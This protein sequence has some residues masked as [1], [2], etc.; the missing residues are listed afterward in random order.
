MNEAVSTSGSNSNWDR[1]TKRPAM[2]AGRTADDIETWE[3]LVERVR[4]VAQ[5]RGWNKTEVGR[6]AEFTSSAFSQWYS[7]SY[8][9]RL[10]RQNEQ[11][12][13]WLEAVENQQELVS[14]IPTGPGFLRLRTASEIINTL[15]WAQ[16]CPD[17]VVITAA[18]G[19]GKTAACRYYQAVTPHVHMVTISPHTKT[20]HGMLVALVGA[21]GVTQHNP[22]RYVEAIGQRLEAQGGHTLLIVDEAQNLVDDAINQLR[23]FVDIN[24]CG[25]ALVGNEEIYARFT[26]R[27]DGPSYAQ[28]KRRIGKRLKRNKP[29]AEDL[30]A[31]I[32]AWGVTD[33]DAVRFL[34]GVGMKG[35]ALGQ[36]DKTMKLA[37]MLSMSEGAEQVTA[38]HIRDA[39]SN[40]DVEDMA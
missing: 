20:V 39:W 38:T 35:G 30:T 11:I 4:E 6:R 10:D 7:G 17:L 36:I 8:M 31:Y 15:Q 26:R 32:A 37:S 27:A 18:S 19:L 21:L 2:I 1:P 33:P 14:A 12:R 25:I 28:L 9:G 5:A 23:H 29:Y 40:R 16:I 34:T 13:R 24:R 22:A 3:G